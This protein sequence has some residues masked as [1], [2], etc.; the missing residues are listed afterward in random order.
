MGLLN[1]LACVGMRARRWTA[2]RGVLRTLAVGLALL[3]SS[4]CIGRG[5][6][7]APIISI[8][9]PRSGATSTTADLRIVGYAL[10]D[11][12]VAAI[13][14]EGRDL[15]SESIYAGERG[16]RLVE[17]AFTIQNL[18]DGEVTIT[19][20]VEDMGGMV[21]TLPYRLQLDSTPPE[22][23]LTA[24][25]SA[26]AGV[27]RVEGVARDNTVVTSVRINDVPL[28]FT[29]AAEFAFRVDVAD[30]QGG[31]IVV[32]D[33]AGNVTRRTLR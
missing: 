22:L 3:G 17:F 18:R 28:Q 29:P 33:A 20:E 4:G 10:D 23:E 6:A 9:E 24:V 2:F 26:G 7:M 1:D 19:I 31:E 8:R 13:R 5:D 16:R 15:L 12:G 25:T 11:Q 27:V 14:V 21:T 32:E 30:V